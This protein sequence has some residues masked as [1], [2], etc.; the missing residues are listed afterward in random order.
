MT[1]AIYLGPPGSQVELAYPDSRPKDISV[2][3]R[4]IEMADGSKV[5]HH[6]SAWGEWTLSWTD[7]TEAEM[8]EIQ[9]EYERLQELSFVIGTVSYPIICV[10][11]SF[12]ADPVP[13]SSPILYNV[14][15][16]LTQSSS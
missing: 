13:A 5:L 2:R 6:A 14:S 8:T 4:I 9:T 12:R 3:G 15:L 7:L 1:E 16:G 11:N 10:L